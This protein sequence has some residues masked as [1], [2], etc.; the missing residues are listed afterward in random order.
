[1]RRVALLLA[2]TLV[3]AVASGA[4]SFFLDR[5]GVLWN[6]LPSEEGLVLTGERD[7][8]VITRTTVPFVLGFDVNQDV[9][10]QVAA[11][12]LTGKVVVVW[13]RNWTTTASEIMMAVWY[14]GS[15]ERIEHLSHDLLAYP[16]NPAIQLTSVSTPVQDP[17]NPNDPTKATVVQDSFLHVVWWEGSQQSHGTYVLLRLTADPSDPD[18]LVE[19]NLDSYAT[20]GFACQVPLPAGVLE[21][22][23][24]A[25]QHATD[26]ALLFF[27]TQRVCLFHLLEVRF[28]LDTQITPVTGSG[29]I[30]VIAQRGRHVPIFGVRKTLAMVDAL[31]ME[32]ARMV[33]GSD[34][35][36]VAYRV[37]G[38][39]LQ[40]VTY[41]DQGWSPL[42]T[43]AVKDGLTMDQAIP[44][45]ENL[46]R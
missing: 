42:R 5:N 14:D 38:A 12:E 27:G 9:A 21:H 7:G 18:A 29:G 20:I 23:V 13:Q 45:V 43:L 26:R 16:R 24:F 41:G 25:N 4:T 40:Y 33:L 39:T 8:Q 1:M 6:G 32:G 3:A 28:A 44:L 11:D 15:W 36:P 30:T 19:Q 17:D 2:C 22:P 37:N 35:A 46:A 31:E 34:L 10:I